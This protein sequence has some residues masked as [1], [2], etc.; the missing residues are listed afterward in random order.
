MGTICLKTGSGLVF[1][2]LGGEL[3]RH[4]ATRTKPNRDGHG[5]PSKGTA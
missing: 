3:S 5:T 1:S 4:G 2:W